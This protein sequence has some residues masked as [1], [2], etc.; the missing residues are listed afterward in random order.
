MGHHLLSGPW[1]FSEALSQH[2]RFYRSSFN[3]RNPVPNRFFY[4][5]SI[6]HIK[7]RNPYATMSLT[8]QAQAGGLSLHSTSEKSKFPACFPSLNPVD[9]Y[10]EHIAESL[11]QVT[12]IDPIKIY[13]RLAWTN[14]LDKG[15]LSLPVSMIT[16]SCLQWLGWGSEHSHFY[17][18]SILTNQRQKP[19]R[20]L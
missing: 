17:P 10:R 7:V 19:P 15:D 12:G 14:T 8:P 6:P 1:R 5:S 9:V 3:L 2:S 11:G 13:Q 4:E 20:S 18:G 16:H